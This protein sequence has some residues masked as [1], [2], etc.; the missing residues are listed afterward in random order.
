VR[1]LRRIQTVHGVTSG[2]RAREGGAGTH[3]V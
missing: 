2:K 3:P 1:K